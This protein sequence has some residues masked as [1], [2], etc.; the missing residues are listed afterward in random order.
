MTLQRHT[1]DTFEHKLFFFIVKFLSS[2]FCRILA[3]QTCR[4]I[5]EG[6][7]G[8]GRKCCTLK[9]LYSFSLS[10]FLSARERRKL[11]IFSSLP[12]PLLREKCAFSVP[13]SFSLSLSLSL[14][15]SFSTAAKDEV[16]GCEGIGRR[17]FLN[18]VGFHVPHTHET[19][20][21]F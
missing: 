6:K 12:P 19:N 17:R 16:W 10:P 5:V 14:S 4:L 7:G 9:C 3:E 1:S 11:G 15:V 20:K 2:P 13:L 21:V 18:G 8:G